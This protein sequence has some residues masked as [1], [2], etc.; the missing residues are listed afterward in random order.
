VAP[1]N[2]RPVSCS[3]VAGGRGDAEPA[4]LLPVRPARPPRVPGSPDGSPPTL[5]ALPALRWA[6]PGPG[7]AAD[8][9]VAAGP[10]RPAGPGGAADPAPVSARSRARTRSAP[11]RQR[12]RRTRSSNR[13]LISS[14]PGSLGPTGRQI[15]TEPRD[16]P[17]TSLN[18]IY[19]GPAGRARRTRPICPRAGQVSG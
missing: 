8:L 14:L 18:V 6:P 17:R 2:A 16:R 12:E 10:G 7:V 3:G 11:R 4:G 19:Y 5:P 13:S 9:G 1:G 15:T